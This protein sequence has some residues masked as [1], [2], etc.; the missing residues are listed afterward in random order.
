MN[1]LEKRVEN[2]EKKVAELI[3]ATQPKEITQESIDTIFQ[4]HCN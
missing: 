2:L 1:E 4:K 3:E